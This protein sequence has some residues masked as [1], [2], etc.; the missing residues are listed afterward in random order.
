MKFSFI[1]L[2]AG[3]GGFRI[4]FD[5][6]GGQCAGFSEIDKSA[7]EVYQNNFH[8]EQEKF[9]GDITKV[10]NLPKVDNEY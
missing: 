7:I 1:D 3:I 8:T 4:A 9:L 6:L 2:F 5:K 10:N